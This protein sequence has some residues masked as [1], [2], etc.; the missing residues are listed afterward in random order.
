VIKGGDEGY[1]R[2]RGGEGL[3]EV[4]GFRMTKGR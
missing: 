2:L 4:S 3:R 1:G